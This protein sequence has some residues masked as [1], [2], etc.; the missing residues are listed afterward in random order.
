VSDTSLLFNF[1]R[2][3]DTASPHMKRVGDNA[4]VM[5]SR[6]RLSSIVSVA[7]TATMVAGFASLGA[8]GVA[9]V[10]ALSPLVGL[11]ALLP[12]LLIAAGGGVAALLVGFSGLGAAMKRTGGG[13]GASAA[14]IAAAERRVEN[15]QRAATQAQRDLND[16]REQAADKLANLS[17]ELARASLDEEAAVLGVA[18]ARRS[19]REAQRSGNRND[20][21]HANLAYRESVQT[22][23]E[24]RARLADVTAEEDRRRAAGVEGSDE[25][26]TALQR[27]ADATRDLAD[28]QAAMKS[29]GGGVD[30]A[31]EAYAKLSQAGKD[32][33]DVLRALGPQWRGVQ[34]VVQQAVFA[35]VAGDVRA[36]SN[37]YLPVLRTQLAA[38][39]VGWNMAF[40]GTAQVATTAGFVDDMN[41]SLANS[42][43]FW[44]RIGASFA[45]FVSGFRQFAVVGSTFLPGIGSWVERIANRFNAWATAA[46]TTGKAHDWI[47]NAIVVLGQFWQILKNVGGAI[48]AVFRAGSGGPAWL[49]GLVDG[50]AA[51]RAF[52]E[53]PAGQEKLAA[54]FTTLRDVGSQLW[55][56]VTNLGPAL[57]DLFSAGGAASDTMSVF[58]TLVGF[59][60]DHVATLAQWMPVLVALY[61]AYKAAT[62]GAV[63]VEALRLPII[64]AQAISSF[65]LTAA[66]RANTAAIL[67]NE[68]AQRKGLIAM[69]ASKVAMVAQAAWT[70]IV[71]AAQWLWNIAMYANPIGLI[72]LAIIALVAG[73]VLLWTHSEG[74]RNFFIGMWDHIWSFLKMIGAWFAGPFVDFFVDSWNWIYAKAVEVTVWIIQKVQSIVDFVTSLPGK[75]AAAAKGMWDGL[76]TSFKAAINWLIRLWNDFHLTLGGGSVLGVSIPSVTL[77]TPN[78]PY[79]EAGGVIARGGAAVVAD[80]NGQGGEVVSL[81][82]G[83]QVTPLS[84][85]A[86]GQTVRVVLDI[87]G[88]EGEMKRMIRK[89][90]RVDGGG[91]VQVA[92]GRE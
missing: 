46:R 37:A 51:L 89:W 65:A 75:I 25:V 80:R 26:Q 39:G 14:A 91:S 11:L 42:A 13:A 34:Q 17:R 72:I 1:L 49:P 62:A 27:Q 21:T 59:A 36:L 73:I 64:A 33:V 69:A 29:G 6:I 56:V 12:S 83:A 7:A 40:R 23:E 52:L 61:V 4:N 84:G 24:V 15:A 10:S 20:I 86:G 57:L 32:L 67:G 50:T 18:D 31:A 5:A 82:T 48:A 81:P 47:A 28:A 8:Q 16:A 54:V 3:R 38:I 87:R 68:A 74:F 66:M 76:V 92:F 58:G 90:V 79:L 9:L 30:Q 60:A 53:S 2:G 88:G 43:T 78:I 71:T 41:T 85:G 44:Q 55:Q 45:P 70:G 35:G 22:L 19:L 63:V 77:D